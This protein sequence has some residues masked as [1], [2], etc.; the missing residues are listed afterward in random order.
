MRVVVEMFGFLLPHVTNRTAELDVPEGITV[1]EV[2]RRL[3][4]GEQHP[5]TASLEGKLVDPGLVLVAGAHIL[6]FPPIAGGCLVQT[7]FHERS[8][9][10]PRC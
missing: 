7:S 2:V 1:G 9:D 8:T 5:W 6:V 10:G 4:I 3:G